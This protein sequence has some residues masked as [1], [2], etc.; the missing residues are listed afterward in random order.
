MCWGSL[1]TQRKWMKIE[2]QNKYIKLLQK[3]V[4]YGIW[5]E[6]KMLGHMEAKPINIT[7]LSFI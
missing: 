4:L 7:Q 1:A 5:K 2:S 6:E 3:L